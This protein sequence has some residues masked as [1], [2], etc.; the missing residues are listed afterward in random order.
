MDL[1]A[2]AEEIFRYFL[3]YENYMA[4]LEAFGAYYGPIQFG[5]ES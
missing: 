3:N 1:E 2:K 5:E 4:E